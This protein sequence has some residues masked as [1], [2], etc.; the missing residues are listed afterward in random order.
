M[1]FYTSRP[2]SLARLI[3]DA[4]RGP[5]CTDIGRVDALRSTLSSSK[6]A[7]YHQAPGLRAMRHTYLSDS[8][9]YIYA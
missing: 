5:K 1:R 9:V 7:A 6:N 4:P 3:H 2:Y 8:R